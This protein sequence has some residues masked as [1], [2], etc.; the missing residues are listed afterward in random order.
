MR[1]GDPRRRK[2]SDRRIRTGNGHD[3][4]AGLAHLGDQVG[5]GIAHRWR[6]GIGHQRY[7]LAGLE[8][9]DQPRSGLVFVVLMHG[10]QLGADG[11]MIEQAG[12]VAGVLGGDSIDA[13]QDFQ[14]AQGNVLQI[15][16]WCGNYI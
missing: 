10:D 16:N 7:R 6:A 11:E 12:G 2:S 4:Q 1:R 14:R 8:H 13:A 15:S 5:A 3:A 9:F